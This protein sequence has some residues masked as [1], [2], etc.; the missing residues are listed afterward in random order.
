MTSCVFTV[1]DFLMYSEFY[2]LAGAGVGNEKMKQIVALNVF[3][4]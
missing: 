3:E 2:C 1:I 4:E